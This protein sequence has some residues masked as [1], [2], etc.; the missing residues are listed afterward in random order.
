MCFRHK[1]L[2]TVLYVVIAVAPSV[3]IFEMVSTL[4]C[5]ILLH[6]AETAGVDDVSSILTM[7]SACYVNFRPCLSVCPVN[8]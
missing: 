3:I 8:L 1:W 5:K 4:K 6:M 7:L 2:E